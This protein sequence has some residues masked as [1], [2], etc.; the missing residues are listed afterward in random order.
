MSSPSMV[1]VHV[2]LAMHKKLGSKRRLYHGQENEC[3]SVTVRINKVTA[4][5]RERGRSQIYL[6]TIRHQRPPTDARDF[7]GCRNAARGIGTVSHSAWM[8]GAVKMLPF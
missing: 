8:N 3:A 4:G 1:Y 5:E 6:G 7:L 2:A